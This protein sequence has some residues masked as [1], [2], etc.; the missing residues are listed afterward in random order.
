MNEVKIDMVAALF[1]P[2]QLRIAE[3]LIA[4]PEDMQP[5][6]IIQEVL[7]MA[8]RDETLTLP[9]DGDVYVALRAADPGDIED[10][11]REPGAARTLH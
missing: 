11:R 9:T 3:W 10:S 5:D 7:T 1:G 6:A 8:S 2:D 4:V